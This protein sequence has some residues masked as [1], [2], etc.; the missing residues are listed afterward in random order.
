MTP[1]R[2]LIW[3]IAEQLGFGRQVAYTPDEVA[4]ILRLGRRQAYE[5]IRAGRIR[6]VRNGNRWLVPVNA[7]AEF[8][9]AHGERVAP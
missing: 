2:T 9:G 4:Q 6:A 8:V 1:D 5:H 3:E 7:I